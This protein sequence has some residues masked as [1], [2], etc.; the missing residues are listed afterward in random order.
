MGKGASLDLQH[1]TML[2][3]NLLAADGGNH[4]ARYHLRPGPGQ[5]WRLA[6]RTRREGRPHC[7]KNSPPTD[8]PL[9]D[10]QGIL[11]RID[12]STSVSRSG[13]SKQITISASSPPTRARPD[14]ICPWECRPYLPAPA[15]TGAGPGCAPG[16]PAGD[17]GF[18][19]NSDDG[20]AGSSGRRESSTAQ[21]SS[22]S[23]C[24]PDPKPSTPDA[25]SLSRTFPH[26]RRGTLLL[27]HYSCIPVIVQPNF[28]GR[29]REPLRQWQTKSNGADPEESVANFTYTERCW[30]G[31]RRLTALRKSTRVRFDEDRGKKFI[32]PRR[33]RVYPSRHAHSPRYFFHPSSHPGRRS[34]RLGACPSPPL[35]SEIRRG[36]FR[37][38]PAD[39]PVVQ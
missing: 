7:S 31:P 25:P 20:A 23:N 13:E 5:E 10:P 18:H 26:P 28:L 22:W 37:R 3:C 36:T 16:G 8:R 4:F 17:A 39:R 34:G 11:P 33:D 6:L 24:P 38:A 9:V 35:R 14:A 27:I 1:V 15:R 2:G 30:G 19:R 21:N 29:I 32:S 12:E